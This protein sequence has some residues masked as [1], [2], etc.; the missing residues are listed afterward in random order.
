VYLSFAAAKHGQTLATV[1]V[2]T[3]CVIYNKCIAFSRL[4]LLILL[5]YGIVLS[6]KVMDSCHFLSAVS[7]NGESH[8]V[9]LLSF[10]TKDGSCID[11]NS[12]VIE[13]YNGMELTARVAGYVAPSLGA[14]SAL[15]LSFECFRGRCLCGKCIPTLTILLSSIC[16]GLTFLLFRSDLFCGNTDII[17][18]CDV[19]KAGYQSVQ[20]CLVYAFCLVLYYCGPTPEPLKLGQGTDKKTN[21]TPSKSSTTSSFSSKEGDTKKKKKKKKNEPGKGEDWTKEMYEQRRKDKKSKSRGVSG[22]SKEEIFDDLHDSGRANGKKRSKSKSRGK[23][24]G[25]DVDALILYEEGNKNCRSRGGSERGSEHSSRS[26]SRSQSL[27]QQE[28]FDDYVDTDPD[29]MDWSAFTPVQR[30]A[31]Y[32]RQRIKKKERREREREREVEKLREWEEQVDRHNGDRSRSPIRYEADFSHNSVG[33]DDSYYG[34]GTVSGYDDDGGRSY[35]SERDDGSA[36][37]IERQQQYNH[38]DEGRGRRDYSVDDRRSYSRSVNDN[39]SYAEYSY[40]DYTYDDDTWHESEYSYSQSQD[41]PTDGSGYYYDQA[42]LN[43][44][45]RSR[46]KYYT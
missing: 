4:V 18:E 11:H 41:P 42:T 13:N 26:R 31:Y 22:R 34:P 19:G 1:H 37:D 9:G 10:E 21:T 2:K 38:R 44:S 3:A 25:D 20:S 30:E 39:Y 12:F 24:R 46:A 7:P 29:G 8:G 14:L 36:Y 32:E 27:S 23:R 45:R 33:Y 35:Y 15:L 17:S 40:D 28:R 5:V 16:Q 6:I 43:S